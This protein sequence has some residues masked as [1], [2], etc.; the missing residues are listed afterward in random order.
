MY[1][2]QFASPL[3]SLRGCWTAFLNLLRGYA[4]SY[5]P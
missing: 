1:E 3:R 5:E 2:K 4:L